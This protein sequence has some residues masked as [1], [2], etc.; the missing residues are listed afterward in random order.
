MLN[1]PDHHIDK[2]INS[3]AAMCDGNEGKPRSSSFCVI[4]AEVHRRK[5]TTSHSQNMNGML[6]MI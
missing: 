6:K 3:S 1:Y 4:P 2:G 5:L